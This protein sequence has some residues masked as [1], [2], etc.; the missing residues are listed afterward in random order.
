M[1]LSSRSGW[2]QRGD[3][4]PLEARVLWRRGIGGTLHRSEVSSKRLKIESNLYI[5]Y[6]F[7]GESG[8]GKVKGGRGGGPNRGAPFFVFLFF[9][10]LVS[11]FLYAPVN[12]K[13]TA[14]TSTGTY[15][16]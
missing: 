7:E 9:G 14:S 11:V 10:F 16:M 1:C 12:S 13:M 3:S 15:F 2:V 8:V 6:R 5:S 4:Q